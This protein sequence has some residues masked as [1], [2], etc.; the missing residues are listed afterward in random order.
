[1]HKPLYIKL[2]KLSTHNHTALVVLQVCSSTLA[3]NDS[4]FPRWR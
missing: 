3:L 1:M 2:G 4:A